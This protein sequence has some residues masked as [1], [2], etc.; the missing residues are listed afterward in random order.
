[1][2]PPPE[3]WRC[4]RLVGMERSRD[5]ETE[6]T[7]KVRDEVTEKTGKVVRGTENLAQPPCLSYPYSKYGVV[8]LRQ[9]RGE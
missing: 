2:Q 9:A 1:M 8:I 6:K 4:R 3:Q 5:E 7:G